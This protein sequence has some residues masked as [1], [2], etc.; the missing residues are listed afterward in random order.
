[1]TADEMFKEIGLER[2]CDSYQSK[3]GHSDV[4]FLGSR[5]DFQFCCNEGICFDD[6]ANALKQSMIERSLLNEN[7]NIFSTD[8]SEKLFQELG[9]YCITRWER[10]NFVYMIDD[11]DEKDLDLTTLSFYKSIRFMCEEYRGKFNMIYVEFDLDGKIDFNKFIVA[12]KKKMEEE[13]W[14]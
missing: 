3:L 13:G 8:S 5:L 10:R 4:K 7:K 9:F 12:I 2:F 1:M 6:F 14:L 11:S